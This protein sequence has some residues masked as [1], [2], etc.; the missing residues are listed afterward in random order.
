MHKDSVKCHPRK[1]P[2][3]KIFRGSK[4][5]FTSRISLASPCGGPHTE[6]VAF[7]ADG[8]RTTT[9]SLC[10]QSLCLAISKAFRAACSLVVCSEKCPCTMPLPACAHRRNVRRTDVSAKRAS[11]LGKRAALKVTR[12]C[13]DSGQSANARQ[14]GSAVKPIKT[15]REPPGPLSRINCC[16]CQLTAS[17]FPSNPMTATQSP[18]GTETFAS[19][20]TA[21]A[22]AGLQ[23]STHTGR[24]RL[25]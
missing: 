23:M 10:L 19:P 5:C 21:S 1:R 13:G 12:A 18:S 8:Q 22:A 11:P 4:L 20:R 17:A 15:S 2:G 9:T 7:Q 24:V 3:L 25:L 16:T 6:S 14:S